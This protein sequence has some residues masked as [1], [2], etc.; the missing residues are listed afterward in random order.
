MENIA[1]P[2]D[3][4]RHDEK[5]TFYVQEPGKLYLRYLSLSIHRVE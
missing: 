1:L 2:S 4:N 5:K 3:M